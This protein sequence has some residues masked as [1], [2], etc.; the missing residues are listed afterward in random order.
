MVNA[1]RNQGKIGGVKRLCRWRI[2]V[3]GVAHR[4]VK[5]TSGDYGD[6]FVDRMRVRRNSVVGDVFEAH[7]KFSRLARITIEP[8]HFA[9]GGHARAVDPFI[10]I[11]RKDHRPGGLIDGECR[12]H[13]GD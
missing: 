2:G 7:G 1:D 3:E 10:G 13:G 8:K 11:I 5:G 6:M 12:Y 4:D 9:T